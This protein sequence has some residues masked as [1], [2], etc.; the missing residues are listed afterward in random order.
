MVD[1]IAIELN[2]RMAT[3]D[4]FARRVT[5]IVGCGSIGLR[6]IIHRVH[7]SLHDDAATCGEL[8]P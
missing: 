7:P 8:S 3:R 1:E 4:T 2:D 6:H 5:Q